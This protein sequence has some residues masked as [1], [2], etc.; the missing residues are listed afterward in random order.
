LIPSGRTL[1]SI[2]GRVRS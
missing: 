1:P 2:S